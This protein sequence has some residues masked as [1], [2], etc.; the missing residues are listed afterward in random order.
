MN[1]WHFTNKIGIREDYPLLECLLEYAEVEVEP[2][3][4]TDI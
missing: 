1:T 2:A 3:N 4:Q